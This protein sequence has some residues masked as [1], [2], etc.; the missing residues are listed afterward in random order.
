MNDVWLDASKS[1]T[2][3]KVRPVNTGPA[4]RPSHVV[5]TEVV[6]SIRQAFG[7]PIIDRDLA[8]MAHGLHARLDLIDIRIRQRRVSDLL[9]N[10]ASP[11]SATFMP[12]RLGSGYGGV[13][14]AAPRSRLR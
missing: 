2:R 5:T 10:W 4:L 1:L 12:F 11:A 14:P 9:P 3:D 6:A 7:V 13:S 8:R